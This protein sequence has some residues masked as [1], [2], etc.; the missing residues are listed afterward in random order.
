MEDRLNI[1]CARRFTSRTLPIG[2]AANSSREMFANRV[3]D[4]WF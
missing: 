2:I 1:Q 4:L 3:L